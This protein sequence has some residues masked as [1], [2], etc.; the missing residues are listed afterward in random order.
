MSE[1]QDPTVVADGIVAWIKKQTFFTKGQATNYAV[2]VAGDALI[3]SKVGGVTKATQG[4][5][6]LKSHIE[7]EPACKGFTA[8]LARSYN[9]AITGSN[10][11]EMC[12]LAGA[13]VLGKTVTYMKCTGENCEACSVVLTANNVVSG[14]GVAAGEQIG[15][16]HP[17][18]RLALGTQR[19]KW[20]T[21]IDELKAYNRALAAG[22]EDDFTPVVAILLS[23]ESTGKVDLL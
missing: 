11:G 19:G 8:Y 23:Q 13:K 4:M 22:K 6:S 7:S 15:W 20:S 3:I 2:A 10:H 14:N 9:T 1:A 16:A 5:D 17:L 18:G 12:V 21:Q